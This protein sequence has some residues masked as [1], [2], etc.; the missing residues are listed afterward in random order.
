[1]D[2]VNQLAGRFEDLIR[3]FAP[4]HHARRQAARQAVKLSSAWD[5]GK[6]GTRSWSNRTLSSS[7]ADV[8]LDQLTLHTLREKSRDLHRNDAFAHA[9]INSMTDNIVGTG[10]QPR[11]R[12]PWKDLGISRERAM[13]LA[14]QAGHIWRTWCRTADS[15]NLLHFDQ[16]Q[17]LVTSSCLINGDVFVQPLMV[18]DARVPSRYS[19]KVELIEADR[20][21]TPWGLDLSSRD[22]RQGIELGVRGQPVGYWV[23]IAH[24]GDDQLKTVGNRSFRRVPAHS[25]MGRQNILHVFERDRI[26]Q[27]RGRPL[28][29]PVMDLFKDRKDYIEAE[30]IRAQ[31]GACFAAFVTKADPW[32]A[33]VSATA[34]TTTSGARLQELSPGLIEYLAPG[35]KVEFGNP[36]SP[37]SAFD[38]FIR[39][40]TRSISSALGMPYEIATRDYSGT[41]YSQARASM[42]EARRMFQRRQRWLSHTFLEPLWRMLLE[43][44]YLL[45]DYEAG[46]DFFDN[47]DLWTRAMWVPPGWGWVDPTKEGQAWKMALEMG[48]TTRS[49]IIAA[50]DGGDFQAVSEELADEIALRQ[51][52]GLEGGATPE[53]EPAQDEEDPDEEPQDEEADQNDEDQEQQD[54][55]ESADPEDEDNAQ[56]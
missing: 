35:E 22:I 6:L 33:A 53:P 24:P 47:M 1:M 55:D 45:G 44:A 31:V 9:A 3:R 13:E 20:V 51:E 18:T 41:T 17:H 26:G 40:V 21:D 8:D 23:H 10:F 11:L 29:A 2:V 39:T 38:G 37:N 50:A 34:D 7:S 42:L 12:L 36:N 27:T 5:G 30:I 25:A 28:L 46:P 52:L 4:V 16:I 54:E 48:T 32:N 14:Q 19:L 56:E 43:E 15:T 49:K